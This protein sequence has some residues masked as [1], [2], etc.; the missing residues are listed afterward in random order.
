M[1]EL[2]FFRHIARSAASLWYDTRGV[3]LPYVTVLLVVLVG[4]SLLAVDGAGRAFSLQTQLQNIADAAALA[5]AAELNRAPGARQRARNAI[6]GSVG[7]GITQLV[8]NGLAGMDV[9]NVAISSIVFYETLPIASQHFSSGTVSPDDGHARFVAVT[10]SH[11]MNTIF[12]VSFLRAGGANSY[13]AGAQAVAGSDQVACQMTPMFIC[14]PF[15][16]GSMTYDQAT[17]A[18]QNGSPRALVA[19]QGASN[20][21]YSPGN[22]GW[23][24]PPVEATASDTCGSGNEVAQAAARNRPL[25]CYRNTSIN[26]HP[27]NITS[28]TDG[29]NT[30]F[31]IYRG[32]F[33]Q[34]NT[35]SSYSPAPNV[36]K[37]WLP[38]TGSSGACNP[39]PAAPFPSGNIQAM[40]FPLDGNMLNADGTPNTNPAVPIPGNGNWPCGDTS[41]TTSD[42][43]TPSGGSCTG[44]NPPSSCFLT[45]TSTAGIHAGMGVTNTTQ[46]ASISPGTYVQSKTATTVL[47]S[48]PVAR[49]VFS[50]DGITFIGYWNTAHPPGTSG[51]GNAPAG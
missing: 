38:G 26:T 30:R 17:A 11:S 48:Q 20:S 46:P 29:L 21:Q 44:G 41:N 13:T 2:Q 9:S 47:L 8:T 49:P 25:V 5:G 16:T 3:M 10:L 19:L 34:C 4:V 33:G 1:K 50:G 37:G 42:R 32:S 22:F 18:L 28:A 27:G 39:D 45:F 51:A 24:D 31:D 7:D 40:G 15:E 36:R 12:P 14:N 23:I 6:Q 35:N 43:T